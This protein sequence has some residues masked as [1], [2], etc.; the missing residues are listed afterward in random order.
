MSADFDF[1]IY[2]LNSAVAAGP[3]LSGL[4]FDK[5]EYT[6]LEQLV[7]NI[8]QLPKKPV[9]VSVKKLSVNGRVVADRMDK[10]LAHAG[11]SSSM[12]KEV[13]KS[14]RHYYI[15]KQMEL[16]PKT[17]HS[18]DFGT[19]VHS[20]ILE[21][22][23]FN[24]VR[25]LPDVNLS[26]LEGC[27]TMVRYYSELL[28]SLYVVDISDMK[29]GD[30]RAELMTLSQKAADEGYTFI[31][32]DDAQII[33]VV[34]VCFNTYGGGIL[35]HIIRYV[36]PEVSMYGNDP[37][38]GLKVKIRPDGLLLSENFGINAI[39]S[40]K[41]TSATSVEAFYRDAAKFRYELAE[42]MYLKVASEITGRPF[43]ATLMLMVQNVAPFQMALIYW[44]AEDLQIGKYKYAQALDVVKSCRESGQWAGFDAFAEDGNFGIIKG[45]LPDWI[46]YELTPQ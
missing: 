33:N 18:F 27:R 29:M 26:T 24:K 45:K 31:K 43:T 36:Q 23:K 12:L 21:P 4:T 5:T 9:R 28:G 14:P 25:V 41:T 6:P 37:E 42:G 2:D 3:D 17:S 34:R 44:D 13:L 38:T 35:P 10:Y 20:A 16:K 8:R 40:V 1:P 46:K 15:A 30:L 7:E 39:L 11:E 19:F 32:A 22:S